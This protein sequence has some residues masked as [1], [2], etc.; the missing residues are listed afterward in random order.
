RKVGYFWLSTDQL[1]SVRGFSR[2]GRL[3]R[4]AGVILYWLSLAAAAG[5]LWK[6]QRVDAPLARTL[7]LYAIVATGLHLL[8]SMHT[9]LRVPLIDPLI[10]VF[11][12]C[13]FSASRVECATRVPIELNTSAR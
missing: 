11:A 12:T 3:L 6:L 5:G 10:C 9:R 4:L 13:F 8:F 1:M 7:V 2:T